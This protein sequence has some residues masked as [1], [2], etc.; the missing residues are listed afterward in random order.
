MTDICFMFEVHQPFRLNRDF[1]IDLLT[2]QRIGKEDLFELYFDSKM[3]RQIFDRV[4]RECYLPANEIILNQIG[5]SKKGKKKFKV[6]YS[7]SGIFVEQCERWNQDV[8]DSFRQLASTNSVELL[9]QTYYHSLASLPDPSSSE[10]IEQI[11]M[12]RQLMVDLFSCEPRVFENTECLYNNTIAKI[13]DSLGYEAMITEGL[14]RI[15]GWRSSNYVY[16]A[17]NCSIRLLLRNYRLSDDVGFRFT[18][19]DWDQWPLTAEKYAGWLASVP[20]QVVNIF[21]DYETFGEHYRRESGILDFL[22]WLPVEIGRWDHL[23]CCTPSEVIKN[24]KPVD[25]IDVP[26]NET[27]SWADTERDASAWL[28]NSLQMTSFNLL[29]ELEPAAKLVKDDELLKIWRHLQTS[30]H[31][32]YMS[33]KGGGPGAV[34]SA[35]NPCGD[36]VEAFLTYIRVLSD[37]EARFRLELEKPEF[38]HKRILR[39]LPVENRFTFFYDFVRPTGLTAR[40]LKEFHSILKIVDANSIRF[41][42]SRGDFERWLHQVVGDKELASKVSRIPKGKV[43]DEVLRNEVARIVEERIEELERS[44]PEPTLKIA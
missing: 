42:V 9:D 11:G 4:A 31:L 37:L 10:F 22:R 6:A 8:L 21:M 38:G 23:Y 40:S 1:Q 44:N 39:R 15:L 18:S 43:N 41:H 12:H 32:Y 34:H 14:E 20:G 13:I 29:R 24:Y 17:R 7:L 25:E 19:E 33:T 28:G 16:K 36:P 35:F 30:D 26:E 2:S 5:R 27:A 3:N